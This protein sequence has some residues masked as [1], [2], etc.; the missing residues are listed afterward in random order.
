[1]PC[2]DQRRKVESQEV[3]Q[4]SEIYTDNLEGINYL[5]P[6]INIHRCYTSG[7]LRTMDKLLHACHKRRRQLYT[8]KTRSLHDVRKMGFRYKRG[9][10][11]L[12][13]IKR[14]TQD[15]SSSYPVCELRDKSNNSV[16]RK[17]LSSTYA[18][19]A[20]CGVISRD[21]NYACSNHSYPHSF[22]PLFKLYVNHT[23]R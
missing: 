14:T 1:M 10:K 4:P 2:A 16:S 17:A 18:H 11:K 6:Y 21:R 22:S 8:W 3:V 20:H 9:T 12:L 23:C 13:I 15:N 19:H 5:S 7:E